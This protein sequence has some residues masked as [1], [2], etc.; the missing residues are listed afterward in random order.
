MNSKKIKSQLYKAHISPIFSNNQLQSHIKT[1][2]EAN[3]N[4]VVLFK[5]PLDLKSDPEQS[6]IDSDY[7]SID[8]SNMVGFDNPESINNPIL[9]LVYE[10]FKIKELL[11]RIAELVKQTK[12]LFIVF[13]SLLFNSHLHNFKFFIETNYKAKIYFVETNE[14]LF[15]F[16]MNMTTNLPTRQKK[17]SNI[18]FENKSTIKL[19]TYFDQIFPDE[20][21]PIW[22]KQLMCIPG[23]S[24]T[25]AH[26]I[27][28]KY[29]YK[30]LSDY[31]NGTESTKIKENHL[32]NIEVLNKKS[33]NVTKIGEAISR[34]VFVFLTSP[35]ETVIN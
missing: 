18:Y 2:I 13:K 8:M 3:I 32:R 20:Y 1:S 23:I 16:F 4:F 31:Y 9:I 34:K 27:A 15:D 33:G 24:E 5:N 17:S 12:E 10:V 28:M 11:N 6:V 21:T 22:I 26:A 29:S 7:E 35:P 25:K 14:K 30:E 19:N